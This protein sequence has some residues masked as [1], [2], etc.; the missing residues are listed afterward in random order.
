[1]GEDESSFLVQ[2]HLL[3]HRGDAARSSLSL[4]PYTSGVTFRL[5]SV[6]KLY[7]EILRHL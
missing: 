2:Y 5:A 6:T 4:P 1:M 3:E 7:G